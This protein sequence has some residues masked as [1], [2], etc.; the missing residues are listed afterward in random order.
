MQSL[1]T[2]VKMQIPVFPQIYRL[3]SKYKISPTQF[4]MS[5]SQVLYGIVASLL[6]CYMSVYDKT[7]IEERNSDEP[8][9]QNRQKLSGYSVS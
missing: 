9:V 4:V 8:Q 7:G 6:V 3:V 1:G 5:N 2:T